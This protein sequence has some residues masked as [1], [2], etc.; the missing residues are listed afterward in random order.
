MITQSEIKY[1]N[2]LAQR[3]FR[4]KYNKFIAEGHKICAELLT[5]DTY[6]IDK[7]YCSNEWLQSNSRVLHRFKSMI[8]EVSEREMA[9]ISQLKTA[10][11]ALMVLHTSQHDFGAVPI[12]TEPVLYL[13][14]VQDPGNV[15]TIIRIADWYGIRHVVRSVGTADFYN[16]KVVQSTMASFANVRLY[17]ASYDSVREQLPTHVSV[18][19]ILGG[20]PIS[21]LVWPVAPLIIMGNESKGITP[22]TLSQLEKKIMLPGSEGRLADSLNVGIATALMCQH[23][24]ANASS[25]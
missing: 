20:E 25:H 18:G 13:D 23:W 12:G 17:S 7:I 19:A 21:K 2:S 4:Q 1:L 6:T 10:N 14:D 16:P 22:A 3:K 11:A 8:T 15:G 24:F 5:A 9:K